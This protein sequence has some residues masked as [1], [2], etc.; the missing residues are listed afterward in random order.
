MIPFSRI[1]SIKMYHSGQLTKY[2]DKLLFDWQAFPRT[3]KV[4]FRG[5][6]DCKLPTPD[7]FLI[8]KRFYSGS[9]FNAVAYRTTNTCLHQID[10]N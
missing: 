5:T 8:E 3:E 4:G 7:R 9:D 10:Y 6:K 2:Q 1:C